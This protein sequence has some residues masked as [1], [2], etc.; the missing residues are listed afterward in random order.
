MKAQQGSLRATLGDH[1]A[2]SFS[3]GQA[4][5]NVGLINSLPVAQ[6]AIARAAFANA[7]SK[8]WILYAC[9]GAVGLLISLLI[10]VNVLDKQHIETKTGLDVEKERRAERDC[11]TCIRGWKGG[12]GL[13]IKH[14][15]G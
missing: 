10:G 5:A 11:A 15:M 2:S 14:T 4:G 7:L 3:G 13:I 9:F 6:K 8:M 1:T 12:E